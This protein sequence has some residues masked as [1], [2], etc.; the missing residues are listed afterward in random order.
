M[1]ALAKHSNA[2]RVALA[3]ASAVLLATCAVSVHPSESAAPASVQLAGNATPM[4][5]ED[6]FHW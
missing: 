1:F 6:G 5:V 3:A 2:F 4:H